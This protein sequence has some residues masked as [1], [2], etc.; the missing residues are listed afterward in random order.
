M[1]ASARDAGAVMLVL[2]ALHRL[3]FTQFLGGHWDAARDLG[4]ARRSRSAAAPD[5]GR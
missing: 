1:L 3:A 4:A 2:Y 5:P